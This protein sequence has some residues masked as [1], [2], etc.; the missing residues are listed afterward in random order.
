[1]TIK[2]DTII[3]LNVLSIQTGT[4]VADIKELLYDPSQNRVLGFLID[5]GG[6]FSSSK[7]IKIEDVMSI[8][9]D[10][11]MIASDE[12]VKT[13]DELQG[14][15]SRI[16][17]EGHYL[18]HNKVV[19]EDGTD[20]GRITDIL[21]EDTSGNVV[22][23]EVSQGVVQDVRGGKKQIRLDDIITVGKEAVI[24]KAFT[25]VAFMEQAEEGGLSG[26]MHEFQEK[27]GDAWQT[28]KEKSSEVAENAQQKIH[29]IQENPEMQQKKKQ[30]SS[31]FT[32]I[33]D[34]V[35]SKTEEVRLKSHLGEME[36]R[37][38]VENIQQNPSE[39]KEKTKGMFTAARDTLEDLKDKA[40][41][42]I[43]Q[44]KDGSDKNID[45]LS[46][47]VSSRKHEMQTSK[48]ADRLDEA[49]GH[50][51]T[52][53]VVTGSDEILAPRGTM[54]TYELLNQAEELGLLE[55]VL[56]NLSKEP[57]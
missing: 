19:T 39:I 36:A 30:L 17:D 27:A 35:Q 25:E 3:G 51:V 2:G 29:E 52:V 50:Y 1:M 48:L 46:S 44:V 16:A 55:K 10:A 14:K 23:F 22:A 12:I 20:L 56:S 13:A 47:A 6:W 53:N 49:V 9:H 32:E 42:T 7:I 18:T 37:D 57:L 21:F 8:G 11:V 24:V 45:S 54:V 28:V 5:E 4:K 41:E 34:T 33:K 38:T 40:T 26:V 43:G 31:K 15:V